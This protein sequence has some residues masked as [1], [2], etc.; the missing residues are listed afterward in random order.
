MGIIKT[1]QTNC[2]PQMQTAKHNANIDKS[3]SRNTPN[4]PDS[5][6]S[7]KTAG[8]G[9]MC[10]NILFASVI[11]NSICSQ[12]VDCANSNHTTVCLAA[13]IPWWYVLLL[14]PCR[15]SLL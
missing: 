8:R 12:L 4:Q 7:A 3:N 14:H 2:R 9:D 15:Y 11:L 1:L 6:Q 10:A 13:C 5:Q